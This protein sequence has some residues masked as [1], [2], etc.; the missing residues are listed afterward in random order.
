[1]AWFN[2]PRAYR[3]G[4][5]FPQS[6]RA[7]ALSSATL[8]GLSGAD[9][10]TLHRVSQHGSLHRTLHD[11]GGPM[12]GGPERAGRVFYVSAAGRQCRDTAK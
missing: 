6:L 1:M 3:W 10:Q 11:E 5:A 2:L 4:Y 8:G 12:C 7:G 9:A